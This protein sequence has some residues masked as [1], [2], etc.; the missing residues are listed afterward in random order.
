MNPSQLV[1]SLSNQVVGT[2]ILLTE[3]FKKTNVKVDI[4]LLLQATPMKL[5]S[6]PLEPDNSQLMPS[7]SVSSEISPRKYIRDTTASNGEWA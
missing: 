6:K 1:R 5:L 2:P 3:H 4:F 7:G